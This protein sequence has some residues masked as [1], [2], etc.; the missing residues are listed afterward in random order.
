MKKLIYMLLLLLTLLIPTQIFAVEV[1]SPNAILID[2]S[3][4][5][6][7]YEK[8]AYESAYPAST[9]KILT[10]ILTLEHCKL[11]ETAKA[12]Y[13]AIMSVPSGGSTANIQVDEELSIEDLLKA[14][15]IC[16]GN[17][18]ANVLAEYIG[19][20]ME[21]FATML[22]TRAK[23]LG[24]KNTNFVNAN[25]LHDENHYTCAYDLAIFAKYAMDNFPEFRELVSTIRFRLPATDKYKS[26]D[27]YF[28]NSNQLII[29]NQGT[30]AKNYYY[31]YATG[32]KTGFTTP[33]KNCLV[34]S[35]EKDGISLI[36]VVLGATQDDNGVSY[37]YT[38]SKALFEYG[39]EELVSGK[40]LAAG[41][42]VETIEVK[43]APK[44]ENALE[45][46]A[47]EDLV[48]S[49][50]REDTENQFESTIHLNEDIKAPISK[51]E[52]LG[53]ITYHIYDKDYT[54]NL[55]ANS[56]VEK[57]ADVI[58]GLVR[59]IGKTIIVVLILAAVLMAVR[60]YNKAKRRRSNAYRTFRYNNRFR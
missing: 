25:G 57:K 56:N 21:S 24:A 52:V 11:D 12:S 10:A 53:T 34:A 29:P 9:T 49:I 35:A 44:N 23:E 36:C 4:G 18:A 39:F 38:D 37:R 13:K 43:D 27:R 3:S 6:I 41:T 20:S 26:D 30:G 15:L 47:E 17:D 33:A 45:L 14:L 48:V 5:R 55:I 51:G 54:V 42:T 2:A 60:S 8:N 50:S 32:I 46:V 16:S 22:N 58:I 59:G 19:G 40:V 7:L 31:Q 1:N 28:L